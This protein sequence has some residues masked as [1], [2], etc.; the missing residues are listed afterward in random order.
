MAVRFVRPDVSD[1]VLRTFGRAL[2]PELFEHHS[3]IVL[4]NSHMRLDVRLN[5]SGHVL[6]LQAGAESMTEVIVDHHAALPKQS[7]LLDYRLR[8]CRTESKEFESGLRYDVSCQLE[9]L[10]L[11]IFLRMNEELELD[12]RR[13]DLSARFPATNRFL[14]GPLS[15]IRTEV[16]RDSMLVYAFHTFPEHCAIVKTQSLFERCDSPPGD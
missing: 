5:A 4:K 9:R 2:H 3:G 11:D 10:K 14:P 16:G 7:Q 8:G 1:L 13:A 12:C 6:V 15:L